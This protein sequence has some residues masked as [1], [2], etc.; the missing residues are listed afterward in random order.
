MKKQYCFM[1]LALLLTGMLV[2]AQTMIADNVLITKADIEKAGSSIPVSAIGEPVGSVSL[3]PAR[4]VDAT[5]TTPAYAVV[6]GSIFPVDANSWPINFRVLLPA[7]WSHRAMQQG[8]GGINGVITVREG[9]NP[10]VSKGFV[11]YGSD[12]G[13]QAAGMGPGGAQSKPLAVGPTPGDEWALN[14]EA[15]RNLAYMQMKKTHDAAMVVIERIYGKQPVYNYYVGNSQ[16]GREGLMVAQRYPA[17][18]DGII[19]NVP[20]V[21]FSTLMLAP[22][23]DQNTGKTL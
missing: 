11:L 8:G 14:E 3:Y 10:M 13:H 17:D 16:G 2:S 21:N 18:Y 7:S 15:I 1:S 23:I 4:W 20:I 5:E 6:E 12:S 9:N 22:R 19:S